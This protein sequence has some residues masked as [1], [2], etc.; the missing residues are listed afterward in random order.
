[1]AEKARRRGT[2]MDRLRRPP[3]SATT[4]RCGAVSDVADYDGFARRPHLRY[5]GCRGA[6]R[7][8]AHPLPEGP[9]HLRPPTSPGRTR[10]PS[11]RTVP[12]TNGRLARQLPPGSAAPAVSMGRL[13]ARRSRRWRRRHRGAYEPRPPMRF[14]ALARDGL[15]D[16]TEPYALAIRADGDAPAD[17]RSGAPAW[18]PLSPTCWPC[19]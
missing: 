6:G 16:P 19:G 14:E 2:V 15:T 8:G 4:A 17:R 13:F 18:L 1:M 12:P 7:R 3:V 11:R 10:R 9:V 5:T